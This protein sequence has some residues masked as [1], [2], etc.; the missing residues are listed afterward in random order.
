MTILVVVLND[1]VR[2]L[3]RHM[4]DRGDY[5]VIVAA[6]EAEALDIAASVKIDMLL[7]EL[8]PSI[9]G[10]SITKNLRGRMPGLPVLYITGWFDHADFAE[11]KGVPI[12]KE[13]FTRD[14][15]TR[16]IDAVLCGGPGS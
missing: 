4:L 5:H 11:L 3:I 13:P 1:D 12:V 9:D 10:R 6:D 2:A 8:A 7:I 16:A 15:L 14:E